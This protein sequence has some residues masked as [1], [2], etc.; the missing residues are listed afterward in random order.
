MATNVTICNSALFLIG[1]EPITDLTEETK[2]AK[3]CNARYDMLK[4][5]LLA[6]HPWNFAT[7]R[8][9][10]ARLVAAPEFEWLYQFQLPSDCLRVL[11][12]QDND[13]G[14]IE[15]EVEGSKLLCDETVIKIKYIADVNEGEMSPHFV[16]ALAHQLAADLAYAMTNSTELSNSLYEK[17]KEE[18]AIARSFDG[19][20]GNKRRYY[21][22][23]FTNERY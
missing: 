13:D 12:I 21:A 6:G 8:V 15:Y 20:E 22:D 7:K 19:Q 10:L 17:A 4:K 9:E 1:G 16:E 5:K 11:S 14:E 23:T 18:L 3:L 2:R